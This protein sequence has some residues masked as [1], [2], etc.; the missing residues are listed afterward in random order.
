VHVPAG[1][2]VH[3]PAALALRQVRPAVNRAAAATAAAAAA[4]DKGEGGVGEAAGPGA[5]D[6]RACV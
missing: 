1:L 4:G 2:Q 5:P 6:V 3:S